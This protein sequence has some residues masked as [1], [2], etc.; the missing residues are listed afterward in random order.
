MFDW[1]GYT[2]ESAS[3]SLS[4]FQEIRRRMC[5]MLHPYQR[6]V[7]V[8]SPGPPRPIVYWLL[9]LNGLRCA[10]LYRRREKKG[11]PRS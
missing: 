7:F 5:L 6:Q 8:T 2:K 11:A 1:L 3:S 4:S 9:T 10:A